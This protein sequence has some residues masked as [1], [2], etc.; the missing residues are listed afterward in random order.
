VPEL[1]GRDR[2]I[3]ALDVDTCDHAMTIVRELDGCV[4]FFKI[5]LQLFIGGEWRR[6]LDQL[7]EREISVFLD[8]KIPDDIGNTIRRVVEACVAARLV[9]FLTLSH[10]VSDATIAV[11][12]EGRGEAKDPQLLIV[13][14]V[15]SV[16][17][18]AFQAVHG[19][20]QGKLDQFIVEKGRCGLRAGCDGLIVSGSA[21]GEVKRQ[22]DCLIVSP[23]IRRAGSARDDHERFTTP[24]EAIRMGSDYLVVGR[25]I[26]GQPTPA[27]RLQAAH[28]I[29]GEIDAAL[30]SM[31]RGR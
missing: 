4:R 18:Q 14:L 9:R 12:R 7:V 25:P 23:G 16:G 24:A 8:L 6:L 3:V 15:S 27:Q 5:G 29:V 19:A 20:N 30:D 11:A 28:A 22:L 17:A 21:I 10:S 26:L 1:K 2:L 13:P 31:R